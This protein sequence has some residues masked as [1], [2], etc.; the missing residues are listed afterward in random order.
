[1][2]DLRRAV[3]SLPLVAFAPFMAVGAAVYY[4]L[5]NDT[6]KVV[7]FVL[8]IVAFAVSLLLKLKTVRYALAGLFSG[9]AV[10]MLYVS[11]VCV[12]LYDLDGCEKQ[13]DCYITEC[14]GSADGIAVYNA[15]IFIDGRK[16][17][18]SFVTSEVADVCDTI[19]AVLKFKKQTDSYKLSQGM[20]LDATVKKLI[21]VNKAHQR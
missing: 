10:M 6:V 8:A 20:L 4:L 14:Y 17:K 3:D 5:S 9:M 21:Y 15:D 13:V 2:N 19:T 7:L 1:M 18:V 12:P 11:A 16:T